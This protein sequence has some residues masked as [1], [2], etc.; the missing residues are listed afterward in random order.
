MTDRFFDSWTNLKET[1]N[2]GFLSHSKWALIT[3]RQSLNLTIFSQCLSRGLA[4]LVNQALKKLSLF[5]QELTS[6][7]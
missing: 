2:L 3:L 6:M 4:R 7:A 1:L 5:F